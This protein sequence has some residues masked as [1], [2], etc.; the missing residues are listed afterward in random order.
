MSRE[1]AELLQSSQAGPFGGVL[2]VGM[3]GGCDVIAA[4]A[5]AFKLATILPAG[6]CVDFGNTASGHVRKVAN[7]VY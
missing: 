2:V 3:G 5:V 4:C 7:R 6:T 1:A